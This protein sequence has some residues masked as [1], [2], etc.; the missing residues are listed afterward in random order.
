MRFCAMSRIFFTVIMALMCVY[1][2]TAS[3][4]FAQGEAAANSK[5]VRTAVKTQTGAGSQQPAAEAPVQVPK[6]NFGITPTNNPEDISVALQIIILLTVLTLAPSILVMATSFTR[7][8]IVLSF[9]R[10][11]LATQQLPSN[12]IIIGLSLILTFFVMTPTFAKI[13]ADSLQPYFNRD[14]TQM[15]AISRTS[16]TLRD[17]MLKQTQ[18]SDLS[19]F[20]KLARD[21]KFEKKSEVPFYIVMPAFILSEMK[22]AFEMGLIIFLP[23]LV[24][25]MVVASVLMSMGMMMLPPA[26][27]SLPFKILI[28]V[29]ADGWHLIIKSLVSSFA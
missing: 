14:I 12:Q 6:I 10:R 8:V 17:F 24:I 15:E 3:S 9:V 18:E 27:I 19:L 28:F 20:I 22:I 16:E 2:I 23:F 4:A 25:D 29:L 1:H 21:K 11:A 7:I 5:P 13:N 26:M